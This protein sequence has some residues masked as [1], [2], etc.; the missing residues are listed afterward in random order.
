MLK[1]CA[2]IKNP[3]NPVC[4]TLKKAKVIALIY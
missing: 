3:E 4:Y 2:L 1:I